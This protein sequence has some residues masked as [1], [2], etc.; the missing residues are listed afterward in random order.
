LAPSSIGQ[1]LGDARAIQHFLAQN[2]DTPL[3]RG[4]AD[5]IAGSAERG[6]IAAER[7]TGSAVPGARLPVRGAGS[8]VR[9]IGSAD[10]ARGSA[11]GGKSSAANS[12][13]AEAGPMGA[14]NR[15]PGSAETGRRRAGTGPVVSG[16]PG[17]V[18]DEERGCIN[19][20]DQRSVMDRTVG[21]KRSAC[22]LLKEAAKRAK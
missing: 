9:A 18:E 1:T 6:K 22:L 17:T 14:W 11:D 4:S 21:H 20:D 15:E 7:E 16:Q 8:A 5:R 10:R 19:D 12:G 13:P 3:G 2:R